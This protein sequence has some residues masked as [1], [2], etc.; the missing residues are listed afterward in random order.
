MRPDVGET[1][2]QARSR[3]IADML[4]EDAAKLEALDAYYAERK[5]RIYAKP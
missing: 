4:T 1:S 5:T 3:E 2:I